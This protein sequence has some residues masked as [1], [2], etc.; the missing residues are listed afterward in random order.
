MQTELNECELRDAE[1]ELMEASH[2]ANFRFYGACRRVFAGPAG[3]F[4]MAY[5]RRYVRHG[6]AVLVPGEPDSTA[7]MLGRQDPVNLIV[8]AMTMSCEQLRQSREA[9]SGLPKKHGVDPMWT[10]PIMD[11]FLDAKGTDDG[12]AES[13]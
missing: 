6:Q 8:N 12:D 2:D 5:L 7:F 9:D 13:R 3:Q 10:G 4:V 1:Q 11:D